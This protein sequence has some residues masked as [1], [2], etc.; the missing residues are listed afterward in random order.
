MADPAA[1][2]ERLRDRIDESPDINEPDRDAL[3]AFSD[4]M[5][6]LKTVYSDH[7]H[8]KLLRHCTLMAE[9]VGVLADALVNKDAAEEIVR[10]INRT[11][12]N[13]ETNR[14]YRV[15]LRVFGRR[16]SDENGTEP[17]D[18]IEWIPSGTSKNYDPAPKPGDML[19]WEADVLPM[20]NQCRNSRDAALIAVAWDSGARSGEI[21]NLDMGDVTDHEHGLQITV[22]GKVGRR[23]ITLIPSV[24]Y[25]QRWLQDHPGKDN[26]SCPLWSKIGKAEGISY[27]AAAKILQRAA[28]RAEVRKP[29][30]FTNFRKSS[31]SWLASHGINQATIEDHHGWKRGSQVASRYVSVFGKAADNE[32]ARIHG[33]DVS[34]DE[35]DPIA[36]IECPRCSRETPREEEFCVW[37]GQATEPGAAE[38]MRKREE[39]LRTAVMRLIRDDPGLLDDV[40]R[41]QDL[42]TVL[43][44]RPDLADDASRFRAAL[45][46]WDGSGGRSH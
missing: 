4:E 5:Y 31:A 17:T 2:I 6:L 39:R 13:E 11:Y 9:E 16:A 33:I 1:E 15:A 24:P 35:P 27:N 10:W 45:D 43:E 36:P 32:L 37:C 42:L 40:E 19:H 14:D 46:E 29:V 21:R 25:L 41:A 44:A 20:V 22:D 30:T 8:V 12:D 7:R 3:I 26:P 23:T 38:T 18:S 28:D 34:K